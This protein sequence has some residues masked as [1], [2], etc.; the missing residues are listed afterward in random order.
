[1]TLGQPGDD[2]WRQDEDYVALRHRGDGAG[3][4]RRQPS[5]GAADTLGPVMRDDVATDQ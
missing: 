4:T 3:A 1:M 2:A 5:D